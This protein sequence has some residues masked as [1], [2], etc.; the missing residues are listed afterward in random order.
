[1]CK[2]GKGGSRET[3]RPEALFNSPPS[4]SGIVGFSPLFVPPTCTVEPGN[5][6]VTPSFT[7]D[8]FAIS[9]APHSSS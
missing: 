5:W 7:P 8:S 6:E 2:E 9:S 1:M 3:Y 4:S